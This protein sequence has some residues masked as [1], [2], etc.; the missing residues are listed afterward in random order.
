MGKVKKIFKAF[1]GFFI[2]RSLLFQFHSY[3]LVNFAL[4]YIM[5]NK[6]LK[7]Q[8]FLWL[9]NFSN[10]TVDN[11]DEYVSLQ[12]KNN[13]INFQLVRAYF[14]CFKNIICF[15]DNNNCY[16]KKHLKR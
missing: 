4:K 1:I 8:Y 10:C 14:Q 6:H 2:E 9:E 13:E 3:L 15:V 12:Q 5:T 16:Y 11:I 7:K